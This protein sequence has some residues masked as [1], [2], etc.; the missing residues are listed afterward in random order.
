MY[1]IIMMKK[2]L[3]Y[4]LVSI[5]L[6][7]SAVAIVADT[8][9]GAPD[10]QFTIKLNY[11]SDAGKNAGTLFGAGVYAAG[12]EVRISAVPASGFAFAEWEAEDSYFD[13]DANMDNDD[14]DDKVDS[15]FIVKVD[16]DLTFEAEFVAIPTATETKN[17]DVFPNSVSMIEDIKNLPVNDTEDDSKDPCIKYVLPESAVSSDI[18]LDNLIWEIL[19]D[20]DATLII[21][22]LNANGREIY[23]WI[24]ME[25]AIPDDDEM[26]VVKIS[27]KASFDASEVGVPGAA[28]ATENAG[29]N[30]V[31]RNSIYVNFD[32]SG[33][34]PSGT[35][36][37]QYVGSEYAGIQYDLCYFNETDKVLE[38][39]EPCVVD[40]EGYVAYTISHCSSYVLAYSAEVNKSNG[41]DSDNTTMYIIAAIAAVIIVAGVVVYF[42]KFR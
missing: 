24:F 40:N 19:D 41:N 3:P 7:T 17:V 25:D 20:Q 21:S 14:D 12:T 18:I 37:K 27:L 39:R 42:V 23:S 29:T 6:A 31:V 28:E 36:I 11:D 32:A 35:V 33:K 30:Y 16:R 38:V 5:L 13:D 2:I 26:G 10:G 22:V 1:V 8:S 9:S 34:L 15:S 4:M